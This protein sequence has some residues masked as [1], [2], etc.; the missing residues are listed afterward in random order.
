MKIDQVAT[1]QSLFL[2]PLVK[3][4]LAVP[5]TPSR[6]DTKR[7]NQIVSRASKVTMKQ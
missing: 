1:N 4:Q 5:T 2:M 6:Q 3:S 7:G